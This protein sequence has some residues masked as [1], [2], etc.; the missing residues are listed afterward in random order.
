[1]K[2]HMHWLAL[3][4]I[5]ALSLF[6]P[7]PISAQQA[8][9]A[10]QDSEEEEDARPNP[11]ANLTVTLPEANRVHVNFYLTVE[12]SNGAEN[13]AAVE[14]ALGCKLELD[15]RFVRARAVLDGS[16]DIHFSAAT[17][18]REGRIWIAPLADYARSNHVERLMIFL[19]LPDT[20]TFD[21]Q[22]APT[23]PVFG[24]ERIPSKLSRKLDRIR[25]Y[26]WSLDSSVPEA[27]T[28]SLGYTQH[29]VRRAGTILAVVLVAPV[30]FVFWLGRKA[31]SAPA[32]DKAAVWF[33]YMR[34]LQWT[35]SGSL[36]GWWIASESIHLVSLL[37]FLSTGWI[38]SAWNFP[39]TA[40]IVDW[41]PPCLVWVLCF[42]LSHPVQEKLRGL[43]WTR[44]ELVLQGVFSVCAALIPLAL[45]LTGLGCSGLLPRS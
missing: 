5:A 38:A 10:A 9:A 36:I 37:K 17:F 28:F 33:S 40:V 7:R 24:N 31:L 1:M 3:I 25:I 43:K 27:I 15:S 45:F 39:V 42:A 12:S 30:L 13:V 20:D 41:I 32:A 8:P 4:W 44:R 16:C 34:Y 19:H 35:L 11:I 29:S 2:K 14:K 26:S 23:A 21:S 6:L 18:R 22:P